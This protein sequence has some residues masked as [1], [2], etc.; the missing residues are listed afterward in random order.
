MFCILLANLRKRVKIPY[1]LLEVNND[2]EGKYNVV[3]KRDKGCL[4][5][6]SSVATKRNLTPKSPCQ[7]IFI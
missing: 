3:P 7:T 1:N 6:L 2:F 5:T 4:P